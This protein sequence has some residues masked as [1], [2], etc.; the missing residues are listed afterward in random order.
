MDT[1]AFARELGANLLAE[2][3]RRRLTRREVVEKF[4]GELTEARL[5]TYECGNRRIP[6]EKLVELAAFYGVEA[7][8]LIPVSIR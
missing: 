2:R 8:G 6:V 5:S 1:R 4:P 7:A 3:A